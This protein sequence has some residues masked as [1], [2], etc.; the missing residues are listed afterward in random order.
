VFNRKPLC[1]IE[2]VAGPKTRRTPAG[3]R[4]QGPNT[5]P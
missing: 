1:V 3:D 4:G 2:M 5:N